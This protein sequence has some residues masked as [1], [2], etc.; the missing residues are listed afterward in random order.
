[1]ILKS[2]GDELEAEVVAHPQQLKMYFHFAS[3]S[4]YPAHFDGTAMD[5]PHGC[6]VLVL[7]PHSLSP[8]VSC[9]KA[10]VD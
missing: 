10:G 9:L 3:C 7:I 1:M 4:D 6:F 5:W 8:N 2:C